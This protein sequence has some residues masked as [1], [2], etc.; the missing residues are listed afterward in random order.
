MDGKRTRNAWF[1]LEHFE[2]D[3]S[4]LQLAHFCLGELVHLRS[5]SCPLAQK[6][7]GDLKSLPLVC[8]THVM[9]ASRI[10]FAMLPYTSPPTVSNS[11]KFLLVASRST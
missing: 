2:S 9:Q 10:V 5:L 1:R 3:V 6:E 7:Q 11:E 4:Y 8:P